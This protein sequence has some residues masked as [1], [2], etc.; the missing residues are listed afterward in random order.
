VSLQDGLLALLACPLCQGP[1]EDAAQ[2]L[3]LHCG[4]CRVAFPVVGDVPDL[5]PES[6]RPLDLAPKSP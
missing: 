4:R 2:G 5:L 3:E 6:A 1:L